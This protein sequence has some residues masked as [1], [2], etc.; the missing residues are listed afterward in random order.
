MGTLRLR[1]DFA[2]ERWRPTGKWIG[3]VEDGDGVVRA[4][5][6]WQRSD[7]VFVAGGVDRFHGAPTGA[8]GQL[9]EEDRV[10]VGVQVSR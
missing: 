9:D 2:N 5:L 1:R 6:L 10:W 3:S 7:N 4:E 8:L